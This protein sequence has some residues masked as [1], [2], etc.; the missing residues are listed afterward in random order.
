M[1]QTNTNEEQ[2]LSGAW[3]VRGPRLIGMI[4]AVYDDEPYA[5]VLPISSVFSDIEALLSDGHL[6]PQVSLPSQK[7]AYETNPTV[8]PLSFKDPLVCFNA[9]IGR[10]RYTPDPS[11]YYALRD[12]D[13]LEPE[14]SK[15]SLVP[16]RFQGIREWLRTSD[17]EYTY[18]EDSSGEKYLDEQSVSQFKG[19]KLAIA[20]GWSALAAVII[21]AFC[22]RLVRIS[23]QD[24]RKLTDITST[25]RPYATLR[26]TS[27]CK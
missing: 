8:T 12:Q 2:G 1:Y 21:A 17:P 23:S 14:S 25:D 13:I 15:S 20:Q 24:V 9:S 11:T 6:P 3:V 22:I 7:L 27:H 4:I 10:K 18:L 26:N 19:S 16:W 5:H